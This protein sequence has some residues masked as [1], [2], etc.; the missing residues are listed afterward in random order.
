MD[1]P[2]DFL[3]LEESA[4]VDQALL[5]S[6]DKFLTRI[7]VY[8]L[9]ALKQIA[10]TTGMP[11]EDITDQQIADWVESDEFVRREAAQSESF[12]QFFT[13]LVFASLKRLKQISQEE[14]QAIADLSLAKVIAWYEKSAKLQIERDGRMKGDR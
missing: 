6:R 10:L 5:S 2:Q 3:T 13:Q 7:T 14:E 11:V 8:S 12:Q 1:A 4:A 9:R